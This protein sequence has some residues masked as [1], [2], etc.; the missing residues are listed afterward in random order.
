MCVIIHQPSTSR[1]VSFKEFQN[2]WNSN[3]DGFGLMY[4]DNGVVHTIKSMTMMDSWEK[5][6]SISSIW[7]DIVLHFRF[8]THWT[9]NLTNTHPFPCGNGKYLVHNGVLG[10]ESD[11]KDKLDFSDTRLLAETLSKYQGEWLDDPVMMHMVE[12]VCTWDK[13]L[14]MDTKWEVHYFGCDGLMSKDK[15]LW[16]SNGAPFGLDEDEIKWAKDNCLDM[17]IPYVESEWF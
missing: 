10:Y 8:A 9:T 11:D 14:V 1:Q 3:P 16:A 13:I 17:G 7:T 6:E 4:A 2:S 12:S 15:E 5:Y